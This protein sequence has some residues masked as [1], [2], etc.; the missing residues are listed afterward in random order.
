MNTDLGNDTEHIV[1]AIVFEKTGKALLVKGRGGKWSFPKGRKK[2][3]E[4]ELAAAQ[5]ETL[6]EAGLDLRGIDYR[7]KI[8]LRYGTYYIYELPVVADKVILADPGTPEEVEA[9]QWVRPQAPAFRKEE[10]NADLRA[11]LSRR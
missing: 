11:W 2:E 5:R 8:Q 1:G 9:V 4:T 6:E 10:K 7:V 3:F